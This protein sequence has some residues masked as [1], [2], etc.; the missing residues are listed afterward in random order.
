MVVWRGLI[1]LVV[2]DGNLKIHT[3]ERPH[4]LL[5]QTPTKGGKYPVVGV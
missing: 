4:H 5:Y 2:G 1:V 3:G